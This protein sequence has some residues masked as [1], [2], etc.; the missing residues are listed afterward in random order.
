MACFT[1]CGF[2]ACNC[3]W[4][5]LNHHLR[6][7]WTSKILVALSP[8]CL[9]I[10]ICVLTIAVVRSVFKADL[11]LLRLYHER[12]CVQSSSYLCSPACATHTYVSIFFFLQPTAF[13]S[14]MEL[15]RM[16]DV[17][18]GKRCSSRVL[19]FES[20]TLNGSTHMNSLLYSFTHLINRLLT[21]SL[22]H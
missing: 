8:C 5:N 15:K 12:H 17:V 10:T 4:K 18:M 20:E 1:W 6:R 21:D 11:W 3:Q 2:Y 13:L 9:N 14:V 19:Y 22:V 7:Q 16:Q